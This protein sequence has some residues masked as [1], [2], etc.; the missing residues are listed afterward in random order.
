[1]SRLVIKKLRVSIIAGF[2]SASLVV[3]VTPANAAISFGPSSL[4]I[5]KVSP[6]ARAAIETAV[7]NAGGTIETKYQYAFDGYVIKMPD[8]LATLL[9]KI[10]NVLTVE[11]DATVTAIT[12]QQYQTPA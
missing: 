4:Y 1:M 3:G 6:S 12:T 9:A 5:I 2:I 7:K 8:M 11:K 10:P